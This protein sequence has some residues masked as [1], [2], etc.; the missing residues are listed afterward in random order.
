MNLRKILTKPS[1]N[2]LFR[3]DNINNTKKK[4]TSLT[5]ENIRSIQPQ[6]T[7]I[8][9]LSTSMFPVPTFLEPRIDL[10][11]CSIYEKEATTKKIK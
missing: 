3:I 9:E 5:F 7:S 4:N 1:S 11:I 8:S 6:N 2:Y 10:I